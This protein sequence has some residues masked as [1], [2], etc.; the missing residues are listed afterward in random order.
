MA[1]VQAFIKV[2]TKKIEKTLIY[3]RLRDGRNIDLF[4][5]SEISVNPNDFDNKKQTI[6]TQI[7]FNNRIEF[8]K[9]VTD[10]KNLILQIYDSEPNKTSVTSDR[11]KLEI[12]RRLR[13]ENY[14]QVD[15]TPVTFFNYFDIFL[16]KHKLSEGR[17]NHFQVVIRALQRFELYTIKKTKKSFKLHLD[18]I[19]PDTLRDIETF[20]KD[21]VDI[22]K[23]M[24]ELYEA[25]PEKRKQLP[26]GQNTLNGIMTKIRT[27]IIWSNDAELTT[28]NPFKKFTIEESKYGTPYYITIEERNQLYNK[29]ISQRPQLAIQRDI[30]VFQCLIGCRIGD[31]YKMTNK[32]VIDGFIEYIARKTK[33]ERPIT[34]RIPLNKTAI[35]ILSRYPENKNGQLLPFI[36][37]QNY[38]YDIKDMFLLAGLTRM[39]TIINPSTGEPEQKQLDKIASSHLARRCFIGNLY[40]KVQDPNLIGEMSG[41]VEGSQAFSRYKH[42]NDEIKTKLINLLD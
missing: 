30:F 13:P 15:E 12:D 3:F 20:L 28:N 19:T 38:N 24:P 10:R 18:T 26:R 40:E 32:N 11:L 21:E 1:T 27:F 41:H 17:R 6:K 25:I 8:N 2:S 7:V 39:I 5:K 33:D 37:E 42:S 23:E 22:R 35:E 34:V 36:S 29:D 31:L 4:Y 14:I 16:E 9:S